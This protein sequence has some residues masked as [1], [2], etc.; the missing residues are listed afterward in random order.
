MTSR[1][2]VALVFFLVGVSVMLYTAT[3]TYHTN[4]PADAVL[5][6]RLVGFGGG[7]TYIAGAVVLFLRS[8][9]RIR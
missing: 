9:T 6:A 7:I 1:G 3:V 5:V 2:I 8:S 4:Q